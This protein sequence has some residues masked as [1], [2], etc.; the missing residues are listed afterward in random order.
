MAE[1][2]YADVSAHRLQDRSSYFQWRTYFDRI[3]KHL[4]VWT[5]LT[6]EE[7]PIK[8][9][10]IEEDC[11]V[12]V[13]HGSRASLRLKGLGSVEAEI[14]HARSILRYQVAYKRYETNKA[15]V[16]LAR[17]LVDKSIL[18]PIYIEISDIEDP[19]SAATYLK[20][21]YG[22]SD[23][24]ARLQIKE[25]ITECKLWKC[26]SVTEYLDK[27][28]EYKLNLKRA[29]ADYLTGDIVANVIANLGRDYDEFRRSW[30]WYRAQYANEAPDFQF[31]RDRLLTQETEIK[32]TKGN[33][34]PGTKKQTNNSDI[35]RVCTHEG[36]P[37]PKGHTADKCWT[38]HPEKKPKKLKE[39]EAAA[40]TDRESTKEYAQKIGKR[41][42]AM[43]YLNP[44]VFREKLRQAWDE[45]MN[46]FEESD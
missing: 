19:H 37:N 13:N 5:I 35:E 46:E 33:N 38:A 4:D 36:C 31:L 26:G 45:A 39:K 24:R 23:E 43:A 11:Y 27:H 15:K 42:A 2:D 20:E 41:F 34:R 44:D 28:M 8:E 29:G 10:P 16:R 17:K 18:E 6:G 30:D 9:E 3:A 21:T 32:K 1:S 12:Y 25:Q 22:V 14:D 7:K 40:T